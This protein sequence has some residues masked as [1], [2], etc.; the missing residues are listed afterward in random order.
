MAR[1]K[2]QS[3]I[4]GTAKHRR[5]EGDYMSALLDSVTLEDWEEVVKST[6]TAAKLGDAQA[7]AISGRKTR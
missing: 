3:L 4:K 7:R 1:R 6:L 5:T 2:K